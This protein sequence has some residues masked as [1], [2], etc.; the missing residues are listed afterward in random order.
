MRRRHLVGQRHVIGQRQLIAQPKRR[1]SLRRMVPVLVGLVLVLAGCADIP[2]QTLPQVLDFGGGQSTATSVP[3]P[4]KDAGPLDIVRD[5]VYASADPANN[6]A[7]ARA[8]LG[9]PAK[10][11]WRADGAITLIGETF[12]TTPPSFNLRDANAGEPA[13]WTVQL[14]GQL[15]GQVGVNHGFAP[16]TG[17][18]DRAVQVGQEP[19]GSWRIVGL[20]NGVVTTQAT[21]LR[22]FQPVDVYYFDP[23]FSVLVPDIRYVAQEPISGLPSRVIDSLLEGPSAPLSNAAKTLIPP[24]VGTQTNVT[25]DDS[26]A[27]VVNLAHLPKMTEHDRFLMIAQIVSSLAGVNSTA[28]VRIES[29]GVPLYPGRPEWRPADLP[30]SY[31]GGTNLNESEP[32]L[33]AEHGRLLSLKDGSPVPGPAGSNAY[34]VVSAAQSVTLTDAESELALIG[35]IAGGE[36]LRVQHWADQS[37]TVVYGAGQ[38]TRPSWSPGY[39]VGGAGHEL[40]TVADGQVLRAVANQQG[41]W[42]VTTVD[43][44]ALAPF[45]PITDLRLS[46]DGVRVAVVAGGHVVVGVVVANQGAVAIQNPTVLR[47]DAVSKAVGLDWLGQDTLAVATSQASTPVVKLSV[48]GL[49]EDPYNTANLTAPTVAIT[50]VG[51]GPVIVADAGGLWESFDIN[52]VWQ[53]APRVQ[54]AGAVPLYPG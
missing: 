40:W 14:H 28:P 26:G 48:D 44:T 11:G 29:D 38:F 33:V 27:L 7:S 36:Q 3:Q 13:T 9:G 20:P 50:A 24:D 51:A 47:P 39:E 15:I 8:Y 19:D 12:G 1:S 30:S 23:S 21:F 31:S 32:G 6:Y 43:A 16:A 52:E 5:F 10:D 37:S 54:G 34:Q 25:E 41:A 22:S 45:G 49:R 46:R 35:Q 4:P 18:L 17:G 2:E 53:P 42:S